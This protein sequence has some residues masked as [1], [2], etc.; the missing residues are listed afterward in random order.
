M[1]H[2]LFNSKYLSTVYKYNHDIIISLDSY[3]EIWESFLFSTG[4]FFYFYF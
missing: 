1:K 3:L 4:F 2:N